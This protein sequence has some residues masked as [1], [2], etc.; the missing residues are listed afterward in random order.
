M[1]TT[2]FHGQSSKKRQ[3][4]SRQRS[5]GSLILSEESR[6]LGDVRPSVSTVRGRQGRRVEWAWGRRGDQDAE[7][8]RVVIVRKRGEGTRRGGRRRSVVNVLRMP[9]D[10][11]RWDTWR[12]IV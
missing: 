7:R 6:V 1:R 10:L 2:F 9:V 3:G 11:L 4:S 5:T 8:G 12:V